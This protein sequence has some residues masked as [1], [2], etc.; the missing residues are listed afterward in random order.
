M[1][2]TQTSI[3]IPQILAVA[4]VGFFAIRWWLAK[5]AGSAQDSRP[6]RANQQID[7]AKIEQVAAMF[8][9]LDRRTIAWDLQRNGWNV[10]GTTERV[11]AGRQLDAPPVSFQPNIPTEG[12]QAPAIGVK[13]NSGGSRGQDLITRYGLQNKVSGKGKEAV[14]SEEQKRAA[15]SS[16]K[17]ARAEGLKRRREEMILAARRKMEEKGESA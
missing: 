10:Q 15:W 8:P 3:N 7:L 6:R 14:P 13:S 16:D 12:Q 5:P 11:L 2:E 4:V 9:Q 1:P 17:N